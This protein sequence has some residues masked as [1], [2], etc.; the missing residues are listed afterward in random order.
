[1]FF[2]ELIVDESVQTVDFVWD[3]PEPEP[4]YGEGDYVYAHNVQDWVRP[5]NCRVLPS[6]DQETFNNGM[7]LLLFRAMPILILFLAIWVAGYYV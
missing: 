5:W 3:W 2:N 6:Y 4:F 7:D 1:M